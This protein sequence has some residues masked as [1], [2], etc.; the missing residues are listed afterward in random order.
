[1]ENKGHQLK[2]VMNISA[3]VVFYQFP[4]IFVYFPRTSFPLRPLHCATDASFS[5]FTVESTF[6][7]YGLKT[8]DKRVVND[9]IGR[10][11]VSY[12]WS[13][14]SVRIRFKYFKVLKNMV[15]LYLFFRHM[16]QKGGRRN[17]GLIGRK[18]K[19]KQWK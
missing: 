8:W 5:F 9:G 17:V 10:G 6:S 7:C 3:A 2:I 16:G 19:T 12:H 1:M 13:T 15:I 14:L 18:L 11:N 4:V